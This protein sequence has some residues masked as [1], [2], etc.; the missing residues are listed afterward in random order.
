MQL[1]YNNAR[2]LDGRDILG[3]RFDFSGA[4]AP[5]IQD[6]R[7]TRETGDREGR[8]VLKTSLGQMESVTMYIK[9]PCVQFLF[10]SIQG[11]PHQCPRDP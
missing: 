2:I 6:R 3:S 9:L 11:N 7:G 10:V 4:A 5:E 1:Y 8:K